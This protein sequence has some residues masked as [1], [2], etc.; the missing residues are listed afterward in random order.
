MSDERVRV[1]VLYAGRGGYH[2]ETISVPGD[3]MEE[4]DRLID[5]IREDPSVAAECYID[6][7][8]LCSAQIVKNEGG[9]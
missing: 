3:G 6:A 7:A 8:R 1:R 5:F 9:E 4:H 2:A